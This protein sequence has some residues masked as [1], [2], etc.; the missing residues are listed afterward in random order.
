M[1]C[2][3][4]SVKTL[5]AKNDFESEL[6]DLVSDIELAEYEKAKTK[7]LKEHAASIAEVIETEDLQPTINDEYDRNYLARTEDGWE[8]MLIAW[9]KGDQTSI[10]GHPE[11]C[12]YHYLEGR[13]KLEL[14]E[15]CPEGEPQLEKVL[16]V[17]EGE[18]YAACGEA[19]SYCNHI[20]RVTCLSET[21]FSLNI[22]SDDAQ[23]GE[24]YQIV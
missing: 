7:L 14:F 1:E 11:M 4:P 19:D 21:G 20:H 10:H 15:L 2:P 23:K 5:L 9:R 16:Y 22:Y 24:E 12:C 13:F 3:T 18:S 8:M 6:E 17:E